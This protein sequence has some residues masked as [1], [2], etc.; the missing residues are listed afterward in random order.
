MCLYN[1]NELLI[2]TNI[3]T[4]TLDTPTRIGLFKIYAKQTN[5]YLT[6]EDYNAHVNYWMPFDGGIGL[7]DA[8]WRK[9]F[10][11]EIYLTDGSH[12]CVNMPKDIT[13]DIYEEV[14]IGTKVL[15]HK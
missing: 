10:G 3:V 8:A 15:V 2:E 13:D 9:K 12:G 11:G 14:S 4:G 7:H 5:R 6:G 1:G